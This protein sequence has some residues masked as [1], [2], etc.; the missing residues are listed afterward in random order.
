MQNNDWKT[1]RLPMRCIDKIIPQLQNG[2][3][4]RVSRSDWENL[5]S[6]DPIIYVKLRFIS[7]NIND[8]VV[9]KIL[10]DD[11]RQLLSQYR[12]GKPIQLRIR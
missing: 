6:G 4:F 12:A 2:N 5:I 7:D 11:R 10:N 3:T 8:D 9:V 1:R